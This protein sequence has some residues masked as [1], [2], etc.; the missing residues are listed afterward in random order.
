MTEALFHSLIHFVAKPGMGQA[1]QE[2]FADCGMLTRPRQIEGFVDVELMQSA[3]NPDHFIVTG[4]W[5]STDSYAAWGAVSQKEAPREALRRLSAAIDS[6]TTGELFTR[7]A[8]SGPVGD[9]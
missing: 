9:A 3:M 8:D 7:L 6:V 4:R 5:R 1:F 2:A